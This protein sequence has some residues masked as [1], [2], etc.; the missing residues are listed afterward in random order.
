MLKICNKV[1]A[2]ELLSIEGVGSG[3]ES[4]KRTF[5]FTSDV[6]KSE[7]LLN[8]GL[9]PLN[10]GIIMGVTSAILIKYKQ[11][12]T[13]IFAEVESGMPDNIAAAKVI[14]VLDKFIGLDID[15]KPLIES[16]KVFEEKLKG[17]MGQMKTAN[18][19]KD[20]KMMSYVG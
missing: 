6:T 5:F 19:E 14:E 2:K 7:Q 20:K 17:I 11:P 9:Q 8:I 16:A 3:E 4:K 10:E 18:N 1:K 13:C 15:P 12:L